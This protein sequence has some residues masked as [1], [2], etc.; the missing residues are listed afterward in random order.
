MAFDNQD[1]AQLLALRAEVENDPLGMGYAAVIDQTN[2]LL[3]LLNIGENNIGGQMTGSLTLRGFLTLA[4]PSEF[5]ANQVAGKLPYA[6]MVM[7]AASVE[8]LDADITDFI[9]NLSEVFSV[10]AS[11]TLAGLAA[12]SRRLSRAE[13]LWGN[14]TSLT[15]TD[16]SLARDAV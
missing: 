11:T 15:R 8:G 16:W 7:S 10:G 4:D 1:N 3:D 12:A 14:G 6:E 2:R 13:F 9:T 5:S